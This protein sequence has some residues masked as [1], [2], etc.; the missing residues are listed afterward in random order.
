MPPRLSALALVVLASIT[1]ASA[2]G[3]TG[4]GANIYGNYFSFDRANLEKAPI[5]SI[6]AGRLSITLQ[7]TR[8]VDVQ[9]AFGGTI[10]TDGA[11]TW[12][13]YHVDNANSWFISNALGGQEFVMMVA[14]EVSS[15]IPSDCEEATAGF[16]VPELN[17]PGLGASSADI[18]AQL[19]GRSGSK[20]AFRADRAGGYSDIAQ[21]LG[22]QLQ[23]GKVVGL[24]LGET[25]IPHV[26]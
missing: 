17:V 9:K 10:K 6:K 15:D 1:P 22:Y 18:R 23:G 11:A 8:L 26:E 25:T 20:I 16:S 13:C 19:G 14:I 21:Y 12:L 3:L 24:G 5:E 7:R 4:M 2:A